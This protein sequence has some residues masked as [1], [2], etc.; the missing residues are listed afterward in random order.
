[1]ITNKN[2]QSSYFLTV[3]AMKQINAVFREHKDVIE[4]W[5]YKYLF[6]PPYQVSPKRIALRFIRKVSGVPSSPVTL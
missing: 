4:Y 5:G 1:M 2:I 6:F 3:K